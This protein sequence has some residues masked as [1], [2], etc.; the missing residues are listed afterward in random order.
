[1]S[2]H[3]AAICGHPYPVYHNCIWYVMSISG[4]IFLYLVCYSHHGWSVQ[5]SAA[6][7]KIKPDILKKNLNPRWVEQALSIWWSCWETIITVL[8]YL[9][10]PYCISFWC[11]LW[12][13]V[14]CVCDAETLLVLIRQLWLMP[15]GSVRPPNPSSSFPFWE[16]Y[17][18]HSTLVFDPCFAWSSLDT[19]SETYVRKHWTL[20]TH[21]IQR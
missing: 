11:I 3:V 16:T 1:M 12:I 6:L 8:N 14:K 13:Q 7:K 18:F 21:L 19:D 2:H 9:A 15:L 20:S 17:L 5:P 4:I 10:L